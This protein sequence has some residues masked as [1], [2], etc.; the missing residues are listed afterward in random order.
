M[1]FAG[2]M[3]V[4]GDL[5]VTGTIQSQTIDSLLQVIA[6]LQSQLSALQVEN[7]LE[8]RVYDYDVSWSNGQ[9]EQIDLSII[10]DG[11]LTNLDYAIIDLIGIDIS[12]ITERIIVRTGGNM[13]EANG[14]PFFEYDLDEQYGNGF[15]AW[16]DRTIWSSE[17]DRYF[18]VDF[19]GG[20][21]Q[22]IVATLKL[23]ITASFPPDSDVQQRK[24]GFQ[25]K[26]KKTVK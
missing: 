1:L 6:D 9:Q 22:S 21:F 11:E 2:E 26:D 14:D 25:S 24:P 10:T 20:G 17:R 8:M 16:G 19:G 23:A 3:E 4:E 7:R 15:T 13:E 5:N 12:S 18:Y